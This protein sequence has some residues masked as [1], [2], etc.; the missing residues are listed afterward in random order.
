MLSINFESLLLKIGF[1]GRFLC[2]ID[3]MKK[4]TVE[5]SHL[6]ILFVRMMNTTM[7]NPHRISSIPL[8]HF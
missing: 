8:M 6:H 3:L 2:T 1:G 7:V 4:V 5:A